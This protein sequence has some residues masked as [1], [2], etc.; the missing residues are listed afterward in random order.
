LLVQTKGCIP[1]GLHQVCK[2]QQEHKDVVCT[3]VA[4]ARKADNFPR[5]HPASARVATSSRC[6]RYNYGSVL[7]LS[8]VHHSVNTTGEP[9]LHAILSVSFASLDIQ[10]VFESRVEWLLGATNRAN[11]MGIR[12]SGDLLCLTQV[13]LGSGAKFNRTG[14]G[15]VIPR[16]E[17]LYVG[18]RYTN[19]TA[20][21]IPCYPKCI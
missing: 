4:G 13:I 7:T 17:I 3:A 15:Q 20:S 1:C 16:R 11:M 8:V 6:E 5:N 9:Y 2:V 19:I 18:G 10:F 21:L 14:L 12:T